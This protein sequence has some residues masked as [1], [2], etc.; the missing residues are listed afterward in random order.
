[1][2]SPQTRSRWVFSGR[3]GFIRHPGA[4][5][6]ADSGAARQP[7]LPDDDGERL[8]GFTPMLAIGLYSGAFL[9][10]RWHAIGLILGTTLIGGRDHSGSV[11]RFADCLRAGALSGISP[12]YPGG[13]VPRQETARGAAC[14]LAAF[15]RLRFSFC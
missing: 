4:N 13:P 6:S 14:R 12:V 2:S 9:K 7:R 3:T 5:R 11:R 8:W 1:M 10:N 15:F